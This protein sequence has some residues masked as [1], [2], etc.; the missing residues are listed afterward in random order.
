MT[1]TTPDMAMSQLS[2]QITALRA[3]RD[4]LGYPW[5]PCPICHG[6]GGCD[7]SVPERARAAMLPDL[8]S[9]LAAATARE[10]ALMG[11]ADKRAAE[12]RKL[13]ENDPCGRHLMEQ[14]EVLEELAEEM[15]KNLTP[16]ATALLDRVEK[17]KAVVAAA[18]EF[19][20]SGM[21]TY[22]QLAEWMRVSGHETMALVKLKDALSA[23]G[24]S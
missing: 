20:D 15:R 11:M 18:S 1:S 23:L 7:H 16:A 3:E 13:F 6:V 12:L 8:A 19:M 22:S 10:A 17:M 5:L 2:D 14:M 9:Q 4:A 24:E 21:N